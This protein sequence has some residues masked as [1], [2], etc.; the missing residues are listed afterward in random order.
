[1]YTQIYEEDEPYT[2][3]GPNARVWKVYN[4]EVIRVD[5]DRIEDWRDGLDSLLVFAALYSAVITTFVVQ[6]STK[7]QQDWGEVTAN[8][9][10]ELI[11]VQRAG[12]NGAPVNSIPPSHLTPSSKF[13][14]RPLDVAINALWFFSLA[15][16]LSTALAAIVCKQWIHQY[17]NMPPIGSPKEK[18][19][20]HHFRFVGL[21]KWHMAGIIGILPIFVHL[22]LGVFFVGLVILLH[23]L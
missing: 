10:M 22:S 1:D 7:L 21:E 4:Q 5:S 6:T 17:T 2:E 11:L 12:F 15:L 20:V 19:H 3:M 8:L 18:A 13:T 23:D 14:P 16:S 9:L